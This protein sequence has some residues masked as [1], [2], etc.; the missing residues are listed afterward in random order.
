MTIDELKL[1]AIMRFRA[2]QLQAKVP[3]V[4]YISGRRGPSA[5]AWAMAGNHLEDASYLAKTYKNG[6]TFLEAIHRMSVGQQK[7]R[8]EISNTIHRLL[9][10]QPE[11][12]HWTHRDGT[13]VDLVPLETP[14]GQLT[15]DGKKAVAFIESCPDTVYFTRR[16]GTLRRWHW[17][18]QKAAE[19]QEV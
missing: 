6:R 2:E 10:S 12:L 17:E 5:Q 1:D 13:A 15:E 3:S 4:E 18:C 9:V 14:D 19:T 11:L 8:W 7:N 16:E